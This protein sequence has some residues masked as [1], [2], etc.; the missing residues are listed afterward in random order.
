MFLSIC[1]IGTHNLAGVS[2][3]KYASSSQRCTIDTSRTLVIW[4]ISLALGWESFIQGQLYGFIIL[5][6]GTLIYNEL[7]IIPNEWF[8][9]NTK[10]MQKKNASQVFG[11]KQFELTEK[12]VGSLNWSPESLRSPDHATE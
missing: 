8:S 2:V 12:L 5:V 7:V 1:S 3:T 9:R 10:E 6:A 11:T 4:V